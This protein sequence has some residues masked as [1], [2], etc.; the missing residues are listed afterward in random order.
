VLLWPRDEKP[1]T[2]R[3][4]AAGWEKIC[5]QVEILEVPGHHHSC[6]SQNSNVVLVGEAMKKA[7]LQAESLLK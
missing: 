1:R 4:P 5:T 7:I 2:A 3:G 6:I